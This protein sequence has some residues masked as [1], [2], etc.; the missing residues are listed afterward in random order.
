[1]MLGPR[2]HG[3]VLE[4]VT[5]VIDRRRTLVVFALVVEGIL[6]EAFEQDLQLLLEQLAVRF[7]VEQ[8][9]TETLHLAGVVAATH[10][11]DDAPVGDDVGHGIIFRHADRMPHRQDVERAAEL[12]PFGLGGEP[13]AELDQV[14]QALVALALE[15]VLGGPQHVVAEAVHGLRD[16]AGG[17]E[18]LAQPLV[19]IA[20]VVGRRTVEP[21]IVELD[22]ADIEDVEVL[23]HC[24]RYA[25]PSTI[26]R[27]RSAALPNTFSAPWYPSLSCAPTPFSTLPNST[28]TTHP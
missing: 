15:V 22:L 25:T 21:D 5:S 18:S 27:S 9:R 20:P 14:G 7:R 17:E 13:Q 26:R 8:R 3:D 12:E 2:H 6:V 19:G 4:P 23:D 16:V 1:Q 28:F 10:P 11:H 24:P